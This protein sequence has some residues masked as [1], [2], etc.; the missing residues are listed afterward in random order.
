MPF[1]KKYLKNFFLSQTYS[2]DTDR[3]RLHD[4]LWAISKHRWISSAT[5]EKDFVIKPGKTVVYIPSDW[6]PGER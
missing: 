6:Q 3:T 4:T 1:Y 5:S 2:T